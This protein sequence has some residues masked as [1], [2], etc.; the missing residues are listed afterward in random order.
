MMM[1][2]SEINAYKTEQM[3][4]EKVLSNVKQ[5]TVTTTKSNSPTTTRSNSPT[6][7]P[8]SPRSTTRGAGGKIIPS[9]L[10]IY[11][12]LILFTC[13]FLF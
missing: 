7:T 13:L 6:T 10:I 8:A 5:A 12:N 11:F 2:N 3:R 4:K 1:L 9:S